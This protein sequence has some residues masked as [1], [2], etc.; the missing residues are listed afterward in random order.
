MGSSNAYWLIPDRVILVHNVGDLTGNDF[1]KVDVQI[2][3]LLH[4][5]AEKHDD[6]VQ[7]L[8]DSTELTKL[9]SVLELEGGRILKYLRED[10]TGWTIVVGHKNNVFLKILSRLLTSVTHSDL[11]V[12][13]DLH[14]GESFIRQVAPGIDVPDIAAWKTESLGAKTN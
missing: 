1:R 14:K 12:A 6:K 9:P 3:A 5:A 2:I 7:V 11:Y 10:N 13:D 8:V 4:E